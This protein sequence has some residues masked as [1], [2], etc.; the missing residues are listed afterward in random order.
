MNWEEGRQG[1]G[2]FKRLL[3]KGNWW[4]AYLLRY[5][6]GSF[7][8]THTDPFPGLKHYRLNVLLRGEDSFRGTAIIRWW[9]FTLFRP[10]VTPHGVMQV[11]RE[12]LVFSL[13]WVW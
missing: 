11:S 9:R 2:Y 1:T 6:V 13:G 5:P 7:I 3:A 10:D 12:R 8:P 4:D